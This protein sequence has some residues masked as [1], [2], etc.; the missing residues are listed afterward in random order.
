MPVCLV[1]REYVRI[2]S[3]LPTPGKVLN[4]S[5]LRGYAVNLRNLLL[6]NPA[7]SAND[8]LIA[9]N[10]VY[11]LCF[12]VPKDR[13]HHFLKSIRQ[14]ITR[15]V[16][17]ARNC[18]SGPLLNLPPLGEAAANVGGDTIRQQFLRQW[19]ITFCPRCG[20]RRFNG[21]IKTDGIPS[22]RELCRG[23]D[24]DPYD[25]IKPLSDAP[26]DEKYRKNLAYY[27]TPRE[28]HWPRYDAAADK[29]IHPSLGDVP[30][31]YLSMPSMLDLTKDEAKSLSIVKIYVDSSVHQGKAGGSGTPNYRKNSCVRG[32]F[33]KEA[34]SPCT[35][36]AKAAF[37]WLCENNT[38]YDFWHKRHE[39]WLST[40]Q[41]GES[42]SFRTTDLLLNNPGIEVAFRPW[43]YPLASYGDS[44][45]KPRLQALDRCAGNALPSI[46]D[47]FLRKMC[48]RIRDY[49][50]DF[51]LQCL[52]YDIQSAKA[53]MAILYRAEELKCPPE[54]VAIGNSSFD[55]FWHNQ[56]RYLADRCRFHKKVPNIFL[57]IAPL[58]WKFPLHS[59]LFARF[60]KAKRLADVQGHMT[61]H[62]YHCLVALL[63]D[64]F[65]DVE[66]FTEVYDYTI[67]I[68]FQSRGTLH[69]HLCGWVKFA[70]GGLHRYEGNSLKGPK[71]AFVNLL[72]ELFQS[73]IDVQCG[74]DLGEAVLNYVTGY[75][76]KASDSLSWKSKEWASDLNNSKWL[77]CY[78]LLCKRAP[79]VPEL[80]LDFSSKPM[81]IHTFS[82]APLYAPLPHYVLQVDGVWL[83]LPHIWFGYLM[84]SWC[85]YPQP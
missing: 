4:E 63:A 2:L 30:E 55:V 26:A 24:L 68:E 8:L 78:R 17:E 6:E 16:E 59:P 48:C 20:L 11:G 76:A 25:M 36:R 43:L 9:F 38:T 82:A 27:I 51:L 31:G 84:E 74:D 47:S 45:I 40:R 39:R 75:N 62:F 22:V 7:M 72:E 58:E 52:L 14:D 65:Q 77:Q 61:F 21:H 1:F 13:L 69:I 33:P 49:S 41:P 15:W 29:F 85:G 70:P 66:W 56:S 19:S 23:C 44:D 37:R 71:S 79:L 32:E 54:N 46:K 83:R 73:S 53:F 81:M 34:I 28:E 64:I 42:P 18:R 67:R 5:E 12:A 57:T 35:P 3:L 10:D 60:K 50:A 80:V